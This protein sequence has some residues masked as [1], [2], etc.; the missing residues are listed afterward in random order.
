MRARPH[1]LPVG[2]VFAC[3]EEYACRDLHTHRDLSG[4]LC[5]EISSPVRMQV[6]EEG[7]GALEAALVM[8]PAAY[9]ALVSVWL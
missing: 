6:R 9:P 3:P 4:C 8:A 2:C 7:I 5:R 1:T